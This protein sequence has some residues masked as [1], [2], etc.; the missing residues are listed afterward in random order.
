MIAEKTNSSEHIEIFHICNG[1]ESYHQN[2]ERSQSAQ[3]QCISN[4]TR[5]TDVSLAYR[6]AVDVFED[7]HQTA[8]KKL[9]RASHA[10]AY[11]KKID[12]QATTVE[13]QGELRFPGRPVIM[14]LGKILPDLPRPNDVGF[15]HEDVKEWFL[16]CCRFASQNRIN[17]LVKP[18][19]AEHNS[20]V[21]LYVNQDFLSFLSELP[22]SM[23]PVIL[24]R[25]S[26]PITGVRDMVDGIIM[27]G[28]N[29]PVETGLLK[30]PTMICGYYGAMD[31]PTGQFVPDTARPLKTSSLVTLTKL[32]WMK[33]ARRQSRF[34]RTFCIQTIRFRRPSTIGR[35]TTPRSGHQCF[36]LRL[37]S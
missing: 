26:Y 7:W 30:I 4:L 6:P 23:H 5:H 21:S 28:G 16:D 19:P 31:C 12:E 35:S 22:A 24:D 8:K 3:F 32:G 37:T 27:W 11:A 9:R 14:L 34:F 20:Q 18:H 17:L 15:I 33:C 10:L 25:F 1:F 13:F 2:L 29:S 36:T